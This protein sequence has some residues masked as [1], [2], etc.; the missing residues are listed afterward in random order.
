MAPLPGP[1]T[2]TL[3]PH[4][5]ATF[6]GPG[7][8]A[9]PIGWARFGYAD[10]KLSLVLFGITTAGN[11]LRKDPCSAYHEPQGISSVPFKLYRDKVAETT[12]PQRTPMQAVAVIPMGP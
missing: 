6:R 4:S 10:E 5:V 12:L 3:A 2:C 8:S 9:H 7:L 11:T 1:L